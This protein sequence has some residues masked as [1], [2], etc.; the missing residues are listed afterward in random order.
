MLSG[1]EFMN[2]PTDASDPKRTLKSYAHSM[3]FT[4]LYYGEYTMVLQKPLIFSDNF[5]QNIAKYN[6]F[7]HYW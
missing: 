4:D 1:L 2:N 6:N 5:S 7:E 3:M